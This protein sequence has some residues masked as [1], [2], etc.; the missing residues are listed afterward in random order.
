MPL[1][2]STGAHS[3]SNL[4]IA[5][6]GRGWIGRPAFAGTS[7]TYPCGCSNPAFVPSVVSSQ[8]SQDPH[9]VGDP[10]QLLRVPLSTRKLSTSPVLLL[11]SEDVT[12]PGAAGSYARVAPI[13]ARDVPGMSRSISW[14]RISRSWLRLLVRNS[15]CPSWHPG[16]GIP[17]LIGVPARP[18]V[19]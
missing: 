17:S 15:A 11:Q 16:V 13:A 5:F 3:C 14:L 6:S 7:K 12:P 18:K 9:G 10:L 8:E 2:G 1:R 19:V 4:P